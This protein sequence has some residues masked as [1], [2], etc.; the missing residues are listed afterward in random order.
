M[1]N[2]SNLKKWMESINKV[3]EENEQLIAREKELNEQL[4][5][6]EQEKELSVRKNTNVFEKVK[7][8]ATELEH[9]DVEKI[10]TIEWENKKIKKYGYLFI[11]RN[12][13]FKIPCPLCG[14]ICKRACTQVDGFMRCTNIKCSNSENAFRI[15][16]IKPQR[17]MFFDEQ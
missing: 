12:V 13:Q 15:S 11:K 4:K 14:S 5:A 3:V 17:K 10:R 9:A 1:D 16:S 7:K 8:I 2:I 6:I